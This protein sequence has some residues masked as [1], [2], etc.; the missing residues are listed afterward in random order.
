MNKSTIDQII[1]F[2]NERD[3]KQFHNGKDLA[4]S[5]SLEA[6]ELLEVY[7][8]SGKDLDCNHKLGLIKSELADIL[9]YATLLA[10]CYNLDIDDIIR[11]KLVI[12]NDKYPVAKAKGISKKYNELN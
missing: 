5:L 1:R 2:R 11:E 3:W 12:N 10:D 7:Q 6:N 4:I 8:W 9:I